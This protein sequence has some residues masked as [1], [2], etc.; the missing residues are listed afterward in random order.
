MIVSQPFSPVTVTFE[1]EEELY[2]FFHLLIMNPQDTLHSWFNLNEVY[3]FETG[4]RTIDSDIIE[5][6]RE[7]M[8]L[9]LQNVIDK[10]WTE[11]CPDGIS[12]A[13]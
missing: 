12:R 10:E 11:A 1:T 8:A 13:T 5:A 6:V 7:R 9:E 3:Q 4:K 2:I